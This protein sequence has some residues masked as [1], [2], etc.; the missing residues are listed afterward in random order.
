MSGFDRQAAERAIEAL[1]LAPSNGE[2]AARWLALWQGGALPP[3]EA[4]RPAHFKTFLPTVILL[5]IVPDVSVTVRLAGTRYAHI[6]G[7]EVTG[8]DWLAAASQDHRATRLAVY[9]KVARGAILFSHRRLHTTD[10]ED[11]I[12]EEIVLPFA[13]DAHGVTPVLAHANVP[14]DRYMKIK[15]AAQAMS[16]PVDYKLVPLVPAV[17]AAGVANVA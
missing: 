12:S 8:M 5:N 13:P 14:V 17:E 3:R 16:E 4:F 2:L 11:Y 7:Q 10:G 1:H 6:L 15:A 9:S